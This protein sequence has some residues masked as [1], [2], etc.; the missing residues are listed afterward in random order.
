[1]AKCFNVK[2]LAIFGKS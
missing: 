1:M 2:A